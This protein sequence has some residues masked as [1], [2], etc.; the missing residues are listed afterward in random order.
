MK[1]NIFLNLSTL[2]LLSKDLSTSLCA[3]AP[4]ADLCIGGFQ[5]MEERTRCSSS[6]P[7]ITPAWPWAS[8]A[9]HQVPMSSG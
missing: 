1:W 9:S 7:N 5:V 6:S 3:Q 2:E 4:E 8:H